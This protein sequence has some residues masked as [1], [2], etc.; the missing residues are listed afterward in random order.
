VTLGQLR[1][2]LAVVRAGSVRGAAAA[3]FVS[4]PSVSAAVGALERE[5]GVELFAPHGRGIR[6][7][8]AGMALAAH[9]RE[10][11]A[12]L[13]RGALAAREA[14]EAGPGP[15]RLAAVTTAGEHLVP[16]LLRAFRAERPEVVPVLEVGN[17]ALVL[18]R[19]AA[20][21]ADLGIGGRPPAGRGIT[22][23]PFLRNDLIVVAAAG[24]PL[25]ARRGLLPAALAGETWLVRE[26]G[27]GTRAA[28]EEYWV[29][30]GI[31]P[32]AVLTL[33]SNGAVTQAAALGLGITLVSAHAVAR[34]LGEGTLVALRVRG[35]P[36]RRS[37]FALHAER[38]TLPGPARRFLDF[39]R[40]PRAARALRAA[41]PRRTGKGGHPAS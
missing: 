32:A 13:D 30:E 37:W 15:L 20:R 25:A 41:Q 7:T 16:P 3:L 23:V 17:R 11:L 12:L 18:D 29:Q 9:A 24:H 39:L 28:T 14:A 26:P 33:G 5:L 27:S 40:S 6:L 22:G 35:L 38:G 31:Q 1:T 19:V 4:E 34:E 8:P 10:A 2:F 36:L 21:E